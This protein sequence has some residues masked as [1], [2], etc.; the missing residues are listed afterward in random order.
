MAEAGIEVMEVMA[1]AEWVVM[2]VE[3]MGDGA[4]RPCML[5]YLSFTIPF[6]SY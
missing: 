3:V 2:D 6:Q 5:N 4:V 1:D